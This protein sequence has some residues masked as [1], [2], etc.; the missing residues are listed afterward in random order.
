MR[1]IK[2]ELVV[3]LPGYEWFLVL[4]VNY[5]ARLIQRRIEERNRWVNGRGAEIET[6]CMLLDG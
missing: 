5:V 4:T 6:D 1:R 3:V 2:L